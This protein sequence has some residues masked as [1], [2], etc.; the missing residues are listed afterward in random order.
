M[1]KKLHGKYDA[2]K[3]GWLKDARKFVLLLVVV[4]LAL[5]LVIGFSFVNGDSMEPTLH[6]K[7]FVMYLRIGQTYERGDIVSVRI[8]SGEY[9]VKRI[10]ALEGDTI[11]LRDGKVYLNGELLNEPYVQGETWE[12]SGAIR[13]PFHLQK[14]QIFVMGDNREVSMDSRSFGVIGR[15]Q[16]KGK[17][18][19]GRE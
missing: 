8:P 1:S 3:Y 18:W 5:Q 9:Y 15:G 17:L 4:Y 6:G 7:E 11:D 14:D 19:P 16:I 2:F 12:R 13:Y 10:I